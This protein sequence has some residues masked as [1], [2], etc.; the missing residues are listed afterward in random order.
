MIKDHFQGEEKASIEKLRE[1]IGHYDQAEKEIL[2]LSNDIV[3]FPLFRIMTGS[4]KQNLA[5]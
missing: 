2:N 4:A 1:I 3:D 5:K